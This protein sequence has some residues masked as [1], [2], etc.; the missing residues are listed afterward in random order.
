MAHVICVTIVTRVIVFLYDMEGPCGPCDSYGMGVAD[1]GV[2]G[3][4]SPQI[5]LRICIFEDS[6]PPYPNP[7][8]FEE[9]LDP[10]LYG[11]VWYGR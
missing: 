6:D 11:M 10:P 2:G 8:P 7:P 4:N 5:S 3:L 9:S 1:G